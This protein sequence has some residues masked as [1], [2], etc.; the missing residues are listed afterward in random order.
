MTMLESALAYAKQGYYI[1]P[2]LPGSRTP[3][4][5]SHGYLDA[6]TD[7]STITTWWTDE[8]NANIGISLLAS[9][10]IMLD[11]DEGHGNGASGM[12]TLA[13]NIPAGDHSLK[14]YM[15]TTPHGGKHF[16][17]KYSGEQLTNHNNL[18]AKDSNEVT[19]VDYT[20]LGTIVAPSVRPEGAYTPGTVVPDIKDVLPCPQWLLDDIK[21]VNQPLGFTT[22]FSI[23]TVS[24]IGRLLNK[25]T[26]GAENGNRD[27][28]LTSVI[29]SLFH[30]GMDVRK[31][32]QL[33]MVINQH[34]VNPPLPQRQVQ[35]KIDS[36][37][38]AEVRKH[39]REVVNA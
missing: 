36:I 24:P 22:D 33:A 12:A 4:K 39:Q 23:I 31:I 9:G 5:D 25:I 8:P 37:A 28:W 1:Y 21:R 26:D 38:R 19:G 2:T 16:F 13:A 34:F 10:L 15:E 6:T 14:T 32:P 30:S 3:F 29:G 35:S 20:A 7:A 18:F 11:I 17:Y 27:N